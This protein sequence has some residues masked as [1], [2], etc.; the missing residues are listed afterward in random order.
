MQNHTQFLR[1]EMKFLVIVFKLDFSQKISSRT[2]SFLMISMI[3]KKK[4]KEFFIFELVCEQGSECECRVYRSWKRASDSLEQ[5]LQAV[6][7]RGR[8]VLRMMSS[9]RAVATEPSLCPLHVFC[10][11]FRNCLVQ[12]LPTVFTGRHIVATLLPASFLLRPLMSTPL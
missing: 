3:F 12:T 8:W 2:Y 5:E 7:T 6:L 9:S 10:N 1:N 11:N 4:E